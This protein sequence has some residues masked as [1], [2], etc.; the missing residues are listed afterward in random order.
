MNL[1]ETR[2]PEDL[3][4]EE[5][6]LHSAYKELAKRFHPDTGGSADEFSRLAKWYDL[7]K[8]R[9]DAGIYGDKYAI[10]PATINHGS[11][12][13]TL[14]RVI[15]RGDKSRVFL[16]TDNDGNSI[17]V[18]I[19]KDPK[20]NSL[21]MNE[22]N[23]LGIIDAEIDNEKRR[24]H[25]KLM[26]TFELMDGGVRKRINVFHHAP[27][28]FSLRTVKLNY[29][30]GVP[31]ED[32]AW[33]FNRMVEAICVLEKSGVVHGGITPDHVLV[34]AGDHAGMLVDY[35][36]SVKSGKSVT[37]T[38]PKWNHFYPREIVDPNGVIANVEATTASDV[39][40]AANCMVYLLGGSWLTLPDLDINK[41][42]FGSKHRP[43]LELLA[44]LKTCLFVGPSFR[45]SPVDLYRSFA[46]LMVALV[47]PKKF[48]P[49]PFAEKY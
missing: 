34:R 6:T 22:V 44:L 37:V 10:I 27:D 9:V 3:F 21:L 45:S 12:S 16:G 7:A 31:F 4:G 13:Y 2:Y 19:S 32:A 39:F 29:P 23:I 14:N 8:K 41:A 48:R 49:I 15:P 36:Q 17:L 35:G 1:E 42:F 18:K 43:P 47:G 25:P 30:D 11:M 28:F 5:S 26:R 38:S 20:V 33:M 46:D 24:Y 40:M